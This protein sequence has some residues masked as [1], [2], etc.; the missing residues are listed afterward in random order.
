MSALKKS[1]C[2]KRVLLFAVAG[3]AIAGAI[4][5]ARADPE[6]PEIAALRAKAEKGNGIAQ[7]N[8][9]LAYTLGR[10]VPVDLTEAFIWLSLAAENGTTG[11]ALESVISKLTD[12]QLADGQRRLTYRRIAL[13]ST[14]AA[15]ASGATRVGGAV[16]TA[17]GGFNLNH[18]TAVTPPTPDASAPKA[19]TPE[20]PPAPVPPPAAPPQVAR[21]PS[22]GPTTG[23]A[24]DLRDP[25][26]GFLQIIGTLRD[27]KQ[28]LT[29]QLAQ[30]RNELAKTQ[31]ALADVNAELAALKLTVT[32]LEADAAAAKLT[33]TRLTVEIN[34]AR[35]EM[36]AAKTSDE[37]VAA[38]KPKADDQPTHLP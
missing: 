37:N 31:A 15:P 27:E 10:D 6:S 16:K 7:F 26:S 23:A 5:P 1:G 36:S 20:L 33:E 29:V 17:T 21:A 35:Q 32:R 25:S 12:E 14:P 9:G 22:P 34:A 13:S 30:A 3:F 19:A 38:V 8:L 4:V 18:S 24:P 28:Q 11:K 2:F